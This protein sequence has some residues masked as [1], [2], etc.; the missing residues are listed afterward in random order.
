M[1][2]LPPAWRERLTALLPGFTQAYGQPFSAVLAPGAPPQAL[3][4]I[5]AIN[6]GADAAGTARA[7]NTL[8]LIVRGGEESGNAAPLYQSGP[9]GGTARNGGG[10]F[11]AQAVAAVDLDGDGVDEII[12]RA[13]YYAGGNLKVLKLVA[14]RLLEIRQSAYDGE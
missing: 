11:V 5:G 1:E 4:L 13:R 9:S 8:N 6:D 10:S 3:T 7:Y 14:G 2:G 12:L